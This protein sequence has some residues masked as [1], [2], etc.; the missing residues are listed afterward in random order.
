[1]PDAAAAELA[2][3]KKELEAQAAANK[4][5]K[6]ELAEVRLENK[7]L[8]KQLK[9]G[10]A[11]PGA[12]QED[13]GLDVPAEQRA[14][15]HDLR[16]LAARR[17]RDDAQSQPENRQTNGEPQAAPQ[18]RRSGGAMLASEERRLSSPEE[19]PPE[20]AKSVELTARIIEALQK[21]TPF[22]TLEEAQ[23]K[24]LVAGMSVP[25]RLR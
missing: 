13:M 14:G 4:E 11:T 20:E 8:Q 16:V 22:D 23:L 24:R 17:K 15:V 6:E 3:L 21:R 10:P 25:H 7:S 5:L 19:L 2:A 18:G 12:S 9:S 1:M